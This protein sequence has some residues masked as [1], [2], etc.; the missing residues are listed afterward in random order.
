MNYFLKNKQLF[1]NTLVFIIII[2]GYILLYNPFGNNINNHPGT[3]VQFIY[4]KF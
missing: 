4:Q 1:I 2:C 3:S